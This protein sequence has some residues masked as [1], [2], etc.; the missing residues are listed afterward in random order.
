MLGRAAYHNPGL[1]VHA[2][3]AL[4]GDGLGGGCDGRR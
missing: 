3:A 1:L 2:D 4:F